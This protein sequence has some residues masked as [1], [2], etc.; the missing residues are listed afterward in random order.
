[1]STLVLMLAAMAVP[2]NGPEMVSAEM[3]Q[4]LDLRGKWESI[5]LA[6]DNLLFWAEVTAGDIT[7][8]TPDGTMTNIW[9]VTDEGKGRLS[10]KYHRTPPV[11]GIYSRTDGHLLI[12]EADLG[13]ER[14]TSFKV[15]NGQTL[16]ILHRVKPRK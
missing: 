15:V 6:G 10:V 13:K 3:E 5:C 16:Y 4:G 11:V 2:G 8:S 1:M 9:K 7:L 12:C 14:P